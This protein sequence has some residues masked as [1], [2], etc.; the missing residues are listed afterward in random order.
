[1]RVVWAGT[2]RREVYRNRQ[3]TRLFVQSGIQPREIREDL[4]EEGPL[5]ALGSRRWSV[6]RRMPLQ[7]LRL[8]VRLLV[9]PS[10]DIYLVTYPG[11]FDVPTVWLA[12]RIRRKPLA[13]DPFV[14]LWDT[15][16]ADRNLATR[17]SVTS[18]TLR[19]V[20]RLALRL[21]DYV[22]ADTHAHLRMYSEIAGRRLKG[23]V[24]PVGSDEA[25]FRPVVTE[26]VDD[27]LVSFYGTYVPLQ[28]VETVVGAAE[29]LP[30]VSFRII[31][32]GQGRP[33]V[34]ELISELGLR[35]VELMDTVLYGELPR[36]LSSAAI[37][38]GIFGDSAKAGNVIPHK[39]Y[40]YL[41]MEKPVITRRSTA[42]EEMGLSDAVITVPPADPVALADT[43]SDLLRDE[44]VR[45][46]V[47]ARGRTV[48]ESRYSSNALARELQDFF[49]S[50]SDDRRREL[51][52]EL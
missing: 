47:A 3:W 14:S 24:L 4:W 51:G 43:I 37:C 45:R 36:V 27:M 28:G 33:V 35:N 23:F 16:V 15:A 18:R 40:D 11:W 5:W 17:S 42:V 12:S 26:P 46:E 20:D 2:F 9:E 30:D 13:F 21:A 39:V 49:K 44:T 50:V 7:Y 8:L 22:V 10:G 41:A 29:L 32:D 48:F 34:E 1:M 6:L 19:R 52:L 25:V 38:L 31:G